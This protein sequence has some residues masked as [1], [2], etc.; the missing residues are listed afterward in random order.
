LILKILRD[1]FLTIPAI[2]AIL[3][4]R[5]VVGTL[6]QSSPVPAADMRITGGA[7]DHHLTGLSG[8]AES[9]ITIDC[10][11]DGDPEEADNLANKMMYCG[12]VGQRLSTPSVAINTIQLIDGPTQS[13]ESAERG[14]DNWRY[15]TSFGLKI[16]W[17]RRI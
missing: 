10:Y 9:N 7:H 6:P 14:T 5:I 17:C 16:N 2:T 11:A 8:G 12:I 1:Y 15:V 13:E 3:E 4:D